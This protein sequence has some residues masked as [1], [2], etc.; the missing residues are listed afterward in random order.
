VLNSPLP[1]EPEL[2]KALLDPLLED[3][4]YWFE[5]SQSLLEQERMTFLT[6]QEQEN[7]VGRVRDSLQSVRAM[8]SLVGA[9]NGEVGVD[10]QV[11]MGWHRLVHECWGVSSRHRQSQA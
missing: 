1:A 4:H 2:L 8:Q 3:F 7:L 11:L 5:R 10:M 6:E 9:T